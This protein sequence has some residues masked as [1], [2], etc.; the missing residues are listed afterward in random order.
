MSLVSE[1]RRGVAPLVA[2]GCGD[3][4]QEAAEQD[5]TDHPGGATDDHGHSTQGTDRVAGGQR[6]PPAVGQG[7]LRQ[8][9]RQECRP[10]D[11][12]RLGESRRTLPA[13]RGGDQCTGGQRPGN[14]HAAEH[15]RDGQG[16]DGA[17]LGGADVGVGMEDPCHPHRLD[18]LMAC[19][20]LT[21]PN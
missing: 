13:E 4:E 7:Q 12:S 16:P 15:L 5:H 18:P 9:Q 3:P 21:V 1:V 17:T 2:G 8:R 10:E 20:D 6:E 14:S 11:P 19:L